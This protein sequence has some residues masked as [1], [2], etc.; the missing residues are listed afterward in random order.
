MKQF[1]AVL[2]NICKCE[3]E[4]FD[5][6]RSCCCNSSGIIITAGNGSCFTSVFYS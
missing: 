4:F 5:T 3:A 2:G 1:A 6:D